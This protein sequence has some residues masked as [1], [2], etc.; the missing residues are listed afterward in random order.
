MLPTFKKST[1]L[2]LLY[3][4]WSL[5]AGCAYQTFDELEAEASV[6]GD[7]SKVEARERLLVTA[8]EYFANQALCKSSNKH[9]WICT[10][11]FSSN[12]IER[13]RAPDSMS[14]DGAIK[15]YKNQRADGCGCVDEV[16][17]K[18]FMKDLQRQL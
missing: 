14:I 18:R 1:L 4:L 2:V 7:Y 9:V 5:L 11:K 8:E 10:R 15:E 13:K 6:T 17:F 12:R 16:G 3:M